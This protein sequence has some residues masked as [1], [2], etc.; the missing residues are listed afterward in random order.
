MRTRDA[1]TSENHCLRERPLFSP[2]SQVPAV[3]KD[4]KKVEV[5]VV[6]VEVSLLLNTVTSSFS[7]HRRV[8]LSR[9][10]G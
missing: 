5:V 10:H 7:P 1:F 6:V 8:N 9:Q 4:S 3:S 2:F